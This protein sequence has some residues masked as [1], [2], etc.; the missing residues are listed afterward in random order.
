MYPS[1]PDVADTLAMQRRCGTVSPAVVPL[2][3]VVW[4]PCGPCLQEKHLAP[5]PPVPGV[6]RRAGAG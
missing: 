3:Q 4:P 5:P 2:H 6:W 1:N